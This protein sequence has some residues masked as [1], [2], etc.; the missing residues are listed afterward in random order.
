MGP[1][2]GLNAYKRQSRRT[3]PKMSI[4]HS[5]ADILKNHVK[6]ELESIDRM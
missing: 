3:E 5:V 2:N 6:Y 1:M 4:P